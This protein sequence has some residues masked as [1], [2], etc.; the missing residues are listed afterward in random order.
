MKEDYVVCRTLLALPVRL[1]DLLRLY[2][3]LGVSDP[4]LGRSVIP[5]A[6][7]GNPMMSHSSFNFS[8]Q[9]EEE[10]SRSGSL[11]PVH[12]VPHE[13]LRTV[14]ARGAFPSMFL[15]IVIGGTEGGPIVS[16]LGLAI[17]EFSYRGIHNGLQTRDLVRMRAK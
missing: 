2:L 5:C 4:Y 15:A 14:E 8:F 16:T 3:R 17:P 13:S 1:L 7:L 10:G 9:F 11:N 12:S 6:L